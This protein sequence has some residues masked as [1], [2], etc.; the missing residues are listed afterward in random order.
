MISIGDFYFDGAIASN[1]S[2]ER[3]YSERRT[4]RGD[5][6]STHSEL[7]PESFAF[8]GIVSQ[9]SQPQSIIRPRPGDDE[10]SPFVDRDRRLLDRMS[11]IYQV[12]H[13]GAEVEVVTP[14]SQ[15]ITAIVTRVEV[16]AEIDRDTYT[17][18]L[19]KVHNYSSISASI[20]PPDQ[21]AE[22]IGSGATTNVGP[23]GVS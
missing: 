12:L 22:I 21:V 18:E 15:K 1:T 23:S 10:D 14:R 2:A 13:E 16:S 8:T 9:I 11:L 5:R 3:V 19:R 7:M 6:I 4:A 17:V 20:Q